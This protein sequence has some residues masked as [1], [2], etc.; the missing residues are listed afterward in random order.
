MQ[1]KIKNPKKRKA[2]MTKNSTIKYGPST[3]PLESNSNRPKAIT[4]ALLIGCGAIST[5]TSF[6]QAWDN[7]FANPYVPKY[8]D[9]CTAF[10]WGRFKVVNGES[11]RFKNPQNKTVAPDGG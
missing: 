4:A 2:G 9:Q 8:S 3:T 7:S 11:L 6:A 10:A 1:Q 5:I